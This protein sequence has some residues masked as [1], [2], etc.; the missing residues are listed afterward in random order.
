MNS[1]NEQIRKITGYSILPVVVIRDAEKAEGLARAL[2][3]GGLPVAEVTFRTEC[4]AE[5]I[6]RITRNVPE[7][8]VG[9][10]TVHSPEQAEAAVAAGAA[11]IVTP[12]LSRPT[13]R[14]CLDHGVPVFPG[15]ASPT[16]IEAAMDLGLDTLKFFPAEPYGGVKTL[17][18]LAGPYAGIRFIP[19]GG[20]SEKNVADYLALKNVAACGGSWIVPSSLVDEGNF[21]AVADLCRKGLRS[22]FG[23]G[24]LHVGINSKDAEEA[25]KTAARFAG[26]FGLPV[27]EYPGSFFAGGMVEVVKGP[28]LGKHGHIAVQTSCIERAAEY[29]TLRGIALNPATASRDESGRLV[30][31][32][33]RDSV[34][35]FAVHLRRKD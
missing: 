34:G 31:I 8:C 4:A 25:G 33:F 11:F 19:T 18:A 30:S 26:L 1:S 17:K 15:C 2:C 35:G 27:S 24:L 14:W 5:A 29:F 32:Y 28:F 13:V 20:V 9:A 22:A 6:R 23:F 12:G 7:I 21:G 16:D 10:G 3:A